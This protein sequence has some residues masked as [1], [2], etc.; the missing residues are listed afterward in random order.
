MNRNVTP[1]IAILLVKAAT[2]FAA[3]C[4]RKAG[5]ITGPSSPREARVREIVAEHF[6]KPPEKL[7]VVVP[8]KA[9]GIDI[10][11]LDVV[12]LVMEIEDV[13]GVTI[14]DDAIA[15]ALGGEK[16]DPGKLSIAILADVAAEAQGSKRTMTTATTPAT[17][18]P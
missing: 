12:D 13:F 10:D 17:G 18:P 11:E 1:W 8:L 5:P 2:L 3:G 9:Q 16:W 4:E 6:A 7:D 14:A 15:S